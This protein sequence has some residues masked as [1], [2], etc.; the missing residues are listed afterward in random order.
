MIK[1]S[2]RHDVPSSDWA[3]GVGFEHMAATEYHRLNEVGRVVEGPIFD[4][5]FVEHKDVAGMT[6]RATGIWEITDL[7]SE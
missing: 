2:L 4:F 7:K 5:Y 6:V 1:A 3:W